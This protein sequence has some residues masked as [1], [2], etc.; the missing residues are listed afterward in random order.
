MK[1]TTITL[2]NTMKM[3]VIGLGTW[4]S[5]KAKVGKAVESAL[6][7]V[8]Y[9]HLDCASIYGNEKEIGDS[10]AKLFGATMKREDIFIT[11]KLWN[12]DHRPE[13]VEGAC[14]KTLSDLQIDYL[15]LYLVH[16]GIAF[17]QGGDLEPMGKDC[18][19]KLEK[20]STRETW[21][22]MEKL[23]DKGL[24]KSIGVANFTTTMLIDLLTYAKIK[25]AVNQIELHPYNSQAELIEFCRYQDI[26]V[27]AYSPL[28][29]QGS[30]L[31]A[32]AV[33]EK[34]ASSH[35]KTASQIL[36]RWAIQRGTIAIPKSTSAKRIIENIDIFDFELSSG[37]MKEIDALNKYER[38]VDPVEWWGVPYFK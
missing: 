15:D 23:V 21:E 34:I 19:V 5:E 36:L 9:K 22:A 18:K 16:W 17:P 38:S 2:I 3:P 28:G 1:N 11:S 4:R 26:A 33:V 8:G 25:P 10:L 27:T 35:N 32:D 6:G 29:G 37:D 31:P 30:K 7:K 13:S 12:T 14:K 24:V 20:I